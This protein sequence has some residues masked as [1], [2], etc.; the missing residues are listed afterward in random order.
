MSVPTA[1]FESG[2]IVGWQMGPVKPAR[3]IARRRFVVARFTGYPKER[4]SVQPRLL[5]EAD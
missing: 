2:F 4:G 1:F 5:V 3:F